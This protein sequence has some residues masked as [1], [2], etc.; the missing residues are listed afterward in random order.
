V[1]P[2]IIEVVT[3]VTVDTL[4]EDWPGPEVRVAE[5]EFPSIARAVVCPES[6]PG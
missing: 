4:P 1:A 3:I 5:D 2:T 6:S